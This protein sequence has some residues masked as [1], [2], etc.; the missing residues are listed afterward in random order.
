MRSRMLVVVGL[1]FAV[2]GCTRQPRVKVVDLS[3]ARLPA[4]ASIVIDGKGD[5]AP[6]QRA[7]VM[8]FE[9]TGEARFLWDERRVYGF[10][11][12]REQ[13]LGFDIDE[14]ICVSIRAERRVAKLFLEEDFRMDGSCALRLRE[15]WSADW[16]SRVANRQAL[17][18]DALR[19]VGLYD[20]A[21]RGFAW[22]VEFSLE[23]K[24]I[25]QSSPQDE[26]VAIHIYRLIPQRPFG[27]RVGMRPADRKD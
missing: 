27:H 13:K 20:V 16:P 8:P 12:K 15:A 23:W 17:A 10:V 5:E 1:L 4:N 18:G 2:I 22:S 21:C 7:A 11:H 19:I 9:E 6:W 24:S 25:S 3:V 26:R 14:Q